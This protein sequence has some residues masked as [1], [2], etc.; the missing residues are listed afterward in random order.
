MAQLCAVHGR[1]AASDQVCGA[2]GPVPGSDTDRD[3][4]SLWQNLAKALGEAMDADRV[5]LWCNDAELIATEASKEIP[6]AAD[7]GLPGSGKSD[8]EPVTGRVTVAI[9]NGLEAV[10]VDHRDRK[11]LV[12]PAAAH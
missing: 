7:D 10:D 8:Q 2:L 3:L 1:V 11:R 6:A 4:D 5:S 12:G 9:V